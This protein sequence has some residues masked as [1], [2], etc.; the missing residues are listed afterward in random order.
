ME[1][2]KII[3]SFPDEDGTYVGYKIGQYDVLHIAISDQHGNIVQQGS[4]GY[5]RVLFSDHTMAVVP[6][7]QFE[8]HWQEV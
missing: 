4:P 1:I 5:Y 6:D 8:A 7:Y 2:Y 3:T